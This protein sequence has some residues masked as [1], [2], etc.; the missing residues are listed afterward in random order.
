MRGLSLPRRLPLECVP[1]LGITFELGE[2]RNGGS[3][4]GADQLIF[5]VGAADEE[6]EPFKL[7]P[8]KV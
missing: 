2:S 7:V 1:G 3:A 8:G 6:T 5:Q 4:D